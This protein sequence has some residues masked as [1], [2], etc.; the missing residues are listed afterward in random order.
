MN[1][2]SYAIL[3]GIGIAA[4]VLFSGSAVLFFTGKTATSLPAI[5]CKD[6]TTIKNIRLWD[7]R[8]LIATYRQ[9]QEIRLY[10]DF[11]DV[12]IDRYWIDNS[13]TQVMLSARELNIDLL[14]PNAQ[15][16]VN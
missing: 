15:T 14:A 5:R 3:L 4:C 7:P 10:Y 16:W 8:P 12:D 13:E 6:S 1:K 2:G 11:R 9:L